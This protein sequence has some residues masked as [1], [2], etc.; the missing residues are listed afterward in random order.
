MLCA[1]QPEEQSYM[2]P[3]AEGLSAPSLTFFSGAK[4]LMTENVMWALGIRCGKTVL[5]KYTDRN[6]LLTLAAGYEI[7]RLQQAKNNQGSASSWPFLTHAFLANGHDHSCGQG[8]TNA[9]RKRQC[10]KIEMRE[11]CLAIQALQMSLA[12]PF[13]DHARRSTADM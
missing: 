10:A 8:I 4:W 13:I 7:R 9:T 11:I 5:S 6:L 2:L 1:H 3:T 12:G